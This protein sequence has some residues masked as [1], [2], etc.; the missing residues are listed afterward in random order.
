MD[1]IG[2]SLLSDHG[3]THPRALS[4]LRGL[5]ALIARANWT[6]PDSVERDCCAIARF[7]EDGPLI[8]ESAEARCRVSLGIH[9]G[10]GVVRIMAVTETGEAEKR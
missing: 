9:Y 6:G 3:A 1:V 10:L 8:L 4:F 2:A 5:Y 7:Q